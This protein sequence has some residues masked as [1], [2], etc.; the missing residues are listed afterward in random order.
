M[1]DDKLD[2]LFKWV[3]LI[4]MVL[5]GI[6]AGAVALAAWATK[7]QIQTNENKMDIES[8]QLNVQHHRDLD[9]QKELLEERRLSNLEQWIRDHRGNLR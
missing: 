1:N 7:I 9:Q 3:D 5:Y 8:S 6:V 4:K 2:R